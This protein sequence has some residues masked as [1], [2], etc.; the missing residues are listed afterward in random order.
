MGQQ[1][2]VVV[3]FTGSSGLGL[4]VIATLVIAVPAQCQVRVPQAYAAAAAANDVPA[5]LLYS[6]ACAESGRLFGS[7][8]R[9]WP[10]ALNVAGRSHFARSKSEALV[11]ARYF[12]EEGHSVDIGLGQINWRWHADR[13]ESL[14]RA[15]DPYRNLKVAAA[16]LREQYDRC[17]CV[18]WWAAVERYHAPKD[19]TGVLARRT[20]YRERVEQCTQQLLDD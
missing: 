17:D 16:I 6:L 4:A 19:G 12:I 13:F 5:F 10:W 15:L 9:P 2:A 14:E 18:D 20:R 7:S 8:L 3:P 1:G 11:V